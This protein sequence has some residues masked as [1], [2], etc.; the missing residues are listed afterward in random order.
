MSEKIKAK[1]KDSLED[2]TKDE[3]IDEYI[4]LYLEKRK[5]EKELKKYKNPHTPSSKKGYDKPQAQG[6]KVG[7]KKGKKT[8]HKGRTRA[9]EK[10]DYTIIVEANQNPKT[11]NTNIKEIGEYD[12]IRVTD[13]EIVKIVKLY[14][15]KEYMD[16]NTGETFFATHKDIPNKGIF[17][18][19][20]KVD[21]NKRNITETMNLKNNLATSLGKIFD[22]TKHK[23]TSFMNYN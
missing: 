16:L 20:N 12:D 17:G 10:V 9:K 7:R 5:L 19:N 15:C 23:Y 14:R 11:G 13:Y 1:I 6:L 18:K 4:E 21:N 22:T 3:I 2:K 8:G